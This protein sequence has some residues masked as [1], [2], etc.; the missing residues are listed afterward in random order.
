VQER[1]TN[2]PV[3]EPFISFAR[4]QTQQEKGNRDLDKRNAECDGQAVKEL[5]MQHFHKLLSSDGSGVHSH[6]MLSFADEANEDSDATYL[7]NSQLWYWC[8]E[9]PKQSSSAL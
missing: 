7:E 8:K 1:L 6:T 4:Y 9:F 3:Q 5:P 2:H